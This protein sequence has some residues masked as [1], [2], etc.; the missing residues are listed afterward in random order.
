MKYNIPV[1]VVA[2]NRPGSLKRVL[3][4]LVKAIFE[5][6]VELIISIDRGDQEE[7]EDIAREFNWPHGV[8]RV[9]VNE[10]RLGLREHIL[11]CGNLVEHYDAIILVEDDLYL[12]P[13]FYDY[14]IQAV[15]FYNNDT[16]IAGI[17]L[18]SQNFNEIP[19]LPFIP[20]P[21]SH[22]VFFMS[23]PS[24]WGQCWTKNQWRL[25][26]EWYRNFNSNAI[27]ENL[28]V[29]SNVAKWPDSS[30]KKF[31]YY[32]LL[33]TEKYFVYPRCSLTSN[34]SDPGTHMMRKK[35]IFQR[36]L[37]Y[38][39]MNYKFTNVG[40]SYAVYDGFYELLPEKLNMLCP[41]LSQYDYEMDIYG[42]KPLDKVRKHYLIS[43]RKSSQP[44]QSWDQCMKPA[45]TNIIEGIKGDKIRFGETADFDM[46]GTMLTREIYLYYFD[47]FDFHL[48]KLAKFA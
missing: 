20:L 47:L 9:L 23:I 11:A 30:W 41:L 36:P 29:P 3:S 1:V 33:D 6:P 14:A 22:D 34:F 46:E 48:G 44:L 26:M 39:R 7:V 43:T 28:M 27:L 15:E 31:Y 21:D 17:S 2:Y 35:H 13:W 18:Y 24:S 25:F 10:T 45:E 40:D 19:F 38:Q 37:Q 12:S 5:W 32:Y 8:K 4:S 16:Q 42:T